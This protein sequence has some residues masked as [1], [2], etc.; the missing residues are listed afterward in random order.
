MIRIPF[1]EPATYLMP[2]MSIPDE[3]LEYW[4]NFYIIHANDI[5]YTFSYCYPNSK[6]MFRGSEDPLVLTGHDRFDGA[7]INNFWELCPN[8]HK[9]P[10]IDYFQEDFLDY[11]FAHGIIDYRISNLT[12]QGLYVHKD[13]YLLSKPGRFSVINIPVSENSVRGT[14]FVYY[15]DELRLTGIRHYAHN[16]PLA[17]DAKVF[18][19]VQSHGNQDP[20]IVLSL[21]LSRSWFEFLDMLFSGQV[22]K[23]N[24][25]IQND[26]SMYCNANNQLTSESNQTSMS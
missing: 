8:K 12:G 20:R 6:R 9:E 18:H 7:T 19:G 24:D 3:T 21:D 1:N 4:R 23:N 22:L 2:V 25:P 17:F 16:T 5:E 13:T 11:C 26:I 15:D 10:I 14:E